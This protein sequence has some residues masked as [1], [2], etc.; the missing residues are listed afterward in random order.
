LHHAVTNLAFL[1]E[2]GHNPTDWNKTK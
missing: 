2:L 1:I